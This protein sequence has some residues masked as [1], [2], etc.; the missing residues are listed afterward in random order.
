MLNTVACS[1]EKPFIVVSH[2]VLRLEF[3]LVNASDSTELLDAEVAL[4]SGLA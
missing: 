2:T 3:L 4:C 1:F